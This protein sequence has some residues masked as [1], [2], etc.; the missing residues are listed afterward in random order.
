MLSD[1]QDH[2]T[3]RLTDDNDLDGWVVKESGPDFAVLGYEGDEV[4]LLLN[5][6]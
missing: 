1:R 5:E 2:T 3:V 6:D 4:R